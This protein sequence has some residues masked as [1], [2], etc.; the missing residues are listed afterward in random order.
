MEP[1]IE[2][3]EEEEEEQQDQPIHSHFG[4]IEDPIRMYLCEIGRAR[5]LTRDDER[6]LARK[7]EG[8]R[9]IC[10]VRERWQTS[11]GHRP[12]GA[13]DIV[14]CLLEQLPQYARLISLLSTQVGVGDMPTLSQV[15]RHPKLR[16]ILDD[17][18][19][20]DVIA[21]LGGD[22]AI[23]QGLLEQQIVELSSAT[24]ILPPG[25][26]DQF[27]EYTA[28]DIQRLLEAGDA[29]AK[30]APLKAR[31]S[32]HLDRIE[33]AGYRSQDSLTEANLRLV[34]SIAKK[35]IGSGMSLLD[36]IQEG[37][38]GLMRAVEKY[39]YR[40][41]FKFSTYATWWIRQGI[42]R[43]IADQSRTIRLPVHMMER[44]NK[45]RRQHRYL[46]QSY[47]RQPNTEELGKAL[48]V[49]PEALE[50]IR[51]ISQLPVSLETP[52]GEEGDAR[53]GDFIEDT[54][55][56]APPEMAFDQVLKQDVDDALDCVLSAREKR[57]LHL[58]FGFE[59]GR[60]RT[61]EEVGREFDVTRERIRQ[62]EAKAL[63][64]LRNSSRF[65]H[66]KG[67]LE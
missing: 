43:A 24:W 53:L 47:G 23:P 2:D 11:N 62:I 6:T 50:K 60:S 61:L 32:G 64:K 3:E 30:L 36:L 39:S 17:V 7:I 57:V 38:I 20:H 63:I 29:A 52:V 42:T 45:L 41:G 13:C 34:V 18:F 19:E 37:N 65:S 21:R 54:E 12:I 31:L 16:T 49:T 55:A 48:E 5:L 56:P 33:V 15:V 46:L 66:L 10:T 25:V 28:S 51:K 8:M 9:H 67:F 1:V 14:V 26:L 22:M 35:Y 4:D 44:I 27:G 59:D 58:R 40:K